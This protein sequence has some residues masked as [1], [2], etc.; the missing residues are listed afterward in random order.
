[1]KPC[2]WC[3]EKVSF[4]KYNAFWSVG[5]ITDNCFEPGT[6]YPTKVEAAAAWNRRSA[7]SAE[8]A[9]AVTSEREQQYR[10]VILF[11]YKGALVLRTVLKKASLQ[12][13]VEAT[14]DLL[15]QMAEVMP[16]LPALSALR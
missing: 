3:G 5:C 9:V 13:G 1:M 8:P 2:P 11:A 16:E 7:A 10:D 4:A 12:G 15:K 14:D 6:G